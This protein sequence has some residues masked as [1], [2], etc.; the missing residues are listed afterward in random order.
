MSTVGGLLHVAAEHAPWNAG[1]VTCKEPS[2]H[3][4]S[5]HPSLLVT[6]VRNFV[7]VLVMCRPETD[8]GDC[9]RH[10]KLCSRP[11]RRVKCDV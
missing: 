10:H 7:E 3:V 1:I 6:I 2:A 4:I 9:R 5:I 8:A 11:G